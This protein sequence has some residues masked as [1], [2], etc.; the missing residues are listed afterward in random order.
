MEQTAERPDSSG[1]GPDRPVLVV[2][3]DPRILQMI[4]WALE[5]E[6][7]VVETARDGREALDRALVS[8]PVLAVLDFGLPHLS[9]NRVAEGLRMVAGAPIPILL[10]TADG[11]A[12]EKAQQVGAYAYLRKPFEVKE[13]VAAVRRGLSTS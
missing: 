8:R 6:G 13:L 5:D 2:D 7:L 9:G 11:K 3:D 1:A 4:C 10:I 12:Q